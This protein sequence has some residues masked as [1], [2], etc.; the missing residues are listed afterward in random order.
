MTPNLRRAFRALSVLTAASYLFAAAPFKLG[1]AQ[2]P[3]VTGARQLCVDGIFE[4]DHAMPEVTDRV[5][6][7]RVKEMLQEM[8]LA[9]DGQKFDECLRLLRDAR[10]ILARY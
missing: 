7:A 1:V 3:M 9:R 10:V 6:Y 5:D 8:E 4:V 2:V